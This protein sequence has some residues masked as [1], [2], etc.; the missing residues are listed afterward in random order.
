MTTATPRRAATTRAPASTKTTT[1]RKPK[2]RPGNA[3]APVPRGRQQAGTDVAGR[4]GP[5]RPVEHAV[6]AAE[7]AVRRNSLFL[8][9]PVLTGLR[10][11][12]TSMSWWLRW[13]AGLRPVG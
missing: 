3:K 2:Q 8:R 4:A 12:P 10:P 7:Q 13:D 11:S 1:P 6:L 5:R 9:V